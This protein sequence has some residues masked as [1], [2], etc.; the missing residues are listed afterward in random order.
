MELEHHE[1]ISDKKEEREKPSPLSE[2]RESRQSSRQFTHHGAED[3]PTEWSY[4]SMRKKAKI[5][6]ND[7]IHFM[8]LDQEILKPMLSPIVSNISDIKNV[9]KNHS[10]LQSLHNK[11]IHQAQIVV[12][13]SPSMMKHLQKQKK[14]CS[15][16]V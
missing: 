13:N 5:F 9:I 8:K 2:G 14:T 15:H 6:S 3:R 16:P 7:T 10:E 1:V 11:A 12:K 4:G